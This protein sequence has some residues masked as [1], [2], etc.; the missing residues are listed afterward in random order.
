MSL[1]GLEVLLYLRPREIL[2]AGKFQLKQLQLSKITS[3]RSHAYK[4]WKGSCLQ[5]RQVGHSSCVE[6]FKV[7]P[8]LQFLP[9]SKLIASYLVHHGM[10]MRTIPFSLTRTCHLFEDLF[11]TSHSL[12]LNRLKCSSQDLIHT[13]QSSKETSRILQA[14]NKSHL[15]N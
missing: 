8:A 10:E 12:P 11:H 14:N 13:E 9:S 6:L 15:S 3:E 2:Q 5:S 1:F 4:G 7:F